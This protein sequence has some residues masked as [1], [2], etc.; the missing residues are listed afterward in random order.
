[1]AMMVIVIGRTGHKK[2]YTS[3]TP[4]NF[5]STMT[6]GTDENFPYLPKEKH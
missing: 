4:R 2:E 3:R 6:L 1:M 5:I